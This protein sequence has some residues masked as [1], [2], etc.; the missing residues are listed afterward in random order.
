MRR[1][2][3]EEPRW[4]FPAPHVSTGKIKKSGALKIDDDSELFSNTSCLYMAAD[5][6]RE[7]ES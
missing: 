3:L 4:P 2:S 7:N 6:A 1:L 5:A